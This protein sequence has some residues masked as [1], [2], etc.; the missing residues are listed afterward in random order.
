M[1]TLV[2]TLFI[3]FIGMSGLCFYINY[4][5]WKYCNELNCEWT[6]YCIKINDNWKQ[7]YDSLVNNSKK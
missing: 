3:A 2:I 6:K 1:K 4:S 5:W 7:L